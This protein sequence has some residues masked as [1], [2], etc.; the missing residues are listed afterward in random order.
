[1][2]SMHESAASL[3]VKTILLLISNNLLHECS[4]GLDVKW[5]INFN[6]RSAT[7]TQTKFL[8]ERACKSVY[9]INT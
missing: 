3:R 2:L 8:L 6:S 1:M 5:L 9:D 4:R 7:Y